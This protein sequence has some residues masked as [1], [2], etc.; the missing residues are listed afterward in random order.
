MRVARVLLVVVFGLVCASQAFAQIG[1]LREDTFLIELA[2]SLVVDEGG[3]GYLD[4]IQGTLWPRYDSGWVNQWYYN[5]PWDPSRQKVIEL[6]LTIIPTS[7][8]PVEAEIIWGY[9]TALWSQFALLEGLDRPPLPSDF[10]PGG[11]LFGQ[12]ESDYMNRM[13]SDPVFSGQ[14]MPGP[15]IVLPPFY[16]RVLDEN[17]ERVFLDIWV[18]NLTS[19]RASGYINHQCI[20]PEP[21][22]MCLLVLGGL[23]LI[24]RVR[25]R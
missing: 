6:G 16:R 23:V 4:P 19:F 17:P 5:D 3:T 11:L 1:Q 20:V 14:V 22:T 15:P 24:G 25:W 18:E 9:S 8:T 13:V 12:P 10:A 2:N 21:T 7:P